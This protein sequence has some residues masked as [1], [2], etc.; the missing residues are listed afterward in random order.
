[1]LDF[2]VRCL[3]GHRRREVNSCSG[4]QPSQ[5]LPQD[6]NRPRRGGPDFK[7]S[8]AACYVFG[9]PQTVTDNV[10]C[11]GSFVA[12]VTVALSVPAAAGGTTQVA[13]AAVG[14]TVMPPASVAEHDVV[15]FWNN[16]AAFVGTNCVPLRPPA[17][18]HAAEVSAKF[19]GI[20]TLNVVVP[21][22]LLI[23]EGDG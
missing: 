10:F 7:S 12:K 11:V 15:T 20:R 2:R 6:A 23:C 9:P 3:R 8:R 4:E 14:V 19:A 17:V 1:L 16:S 22:P 13:C 18:M 5:L 21:S